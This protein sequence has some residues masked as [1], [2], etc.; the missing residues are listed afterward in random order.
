MLAQKKSGRGGDGGYPS[1]EC[2]LPAKTENS[3]N[4]ALGLKP[5]GGIL[6]LGGSWILSSRG[7][8]L[9]IG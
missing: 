9:G 8:V 5:V 6:P 7:K 2:G 3:G 4:Q 1:Q